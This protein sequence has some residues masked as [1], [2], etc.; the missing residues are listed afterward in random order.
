[1]IPIYLIIGLI[2]VLAKTNNYGIKIDDPEM[3]IR[4]RRDLQNTDTSSIMLQHL[5]TRH[6]EELVRNKRQFSF[7]F[8]KKTTPQTT[9]TPKYYFND[10]YNTLPR[11]NYNNNNYYNGKLDYNFVTQNN[12]MLR[13]NGRMTTYN[14]SGNNYNNH[15]SWNVSN[16]ARQYNYRNNGPYTRNNVTGFYGYRPSNV[17]VNNYTY[18]YNGF[19]GT[20]RYP[21]TKTTLM[22]KFNTSGNWRNNGIGYNVTTPKYYDPNLPP[23]Y[24]YQDPNSSNFSGYFQQNF[25]NTVNGTS[26][27]PTMKPYA[28]GYLPIPEYKPSNTSNHW[29]DNFNTTPAAY[30]PGYAST[31]SKY[32]PVTSQ[33]G[34]VTPQYGSTTPQYGSTTP[35]KNETTTKIATACVICNI[36]CPEN[37]HRVGF[38]CEPDD[39]GGD[40]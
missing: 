35:G 28:P 5:L 18:S 15:N 31:T 24:N 19:P 3:D 1:M 20:S 37:Y 17:S 13:N 27:N 26:Y 16:A 30:N 25:T 29:Y 34:P 33:Y 39:D 9:T 12:G 40:Y 22:P 14:T 32:G 38:S 7:F 11:V 23:I 6:S 10:V 8:P 21:L 4:V 2:N 36:G